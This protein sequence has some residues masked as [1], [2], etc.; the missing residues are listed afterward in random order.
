VCL[1]LIAIDAHPRYALVL[2]ANRDEFHQRP[3]APAAWWKDERGAPILAGR[4]LEHGGTWL[5]VTPDGRFAFVTNVREPGRHDPDAPSR[6]VLVPALL[7]DARPPLDALASIV[8]G[9]RGFNGFNLVGGEGACAAFGSNRHG[10]AV[11]LRRGIHG[12]SNANLDTPWPKLVR[13]KAG[14]AAWMAAGVDDFDA[15]WPVL[16]DRTL[17]RDDE[18][19][20]TGIARERERLLSAPFIVSDGYGT[21]CSTI[22]AMSREG[23]VQFVE[24]S[25]DASGAL[26]HEAQ[27]RFQVAAHS[28]STMT[29]WSMPAS[30]NTSP[31]ASNP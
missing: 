25:F 4:D 15:L 21:R 13:A 5:G 1:A 3:A 24:R 28:A 17:A 12:V 29:R 19:P 8:G 26:A 16:A 10:E 6:G 18:L 7:R 22:V 2:A 9:A 11:A 31:V 23:N 20:H 30:S 27:F 14:L